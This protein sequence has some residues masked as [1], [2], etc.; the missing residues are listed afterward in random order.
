[1][2]SQAILVLIIRQVIIIGRKVQ[3]Y[4]FCHVLNSDSSKHKSTDE[5]KYK[6]EDEVE[7]EDKMTTG[8]V[9]DEVDDSPYD[10]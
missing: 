3:S 6:E 10:D 8:Y 4:P 9:N 2:K 7:I 5:I 1:M